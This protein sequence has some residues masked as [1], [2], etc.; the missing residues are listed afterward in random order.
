MHMCIYCTYIQYAYINACIYVLNAIH[1]SD[2][3]QEM[4]DRKEYE[5]AQI[6]TNIHP[7]K[8]TYTHTD[9]SPDF[10][11]IYIYVNRK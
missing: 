11:Y 4:I 1:M 6:R 10:L 2:D 9:D 8:H 3:A 7:Y 5:E